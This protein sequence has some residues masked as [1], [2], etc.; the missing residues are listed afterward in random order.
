MRFSNL[1]RF[2]STSISIFSLIAICLFSK[3]FRIMILKSISEKN[4]LLK[5]KN[6]LK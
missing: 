3:S 2:L 4:D 6:F 1:E 5:I